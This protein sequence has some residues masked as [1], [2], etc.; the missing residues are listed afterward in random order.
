MLIHEAKMGI[1]LKMENFSVRLK[2]LNFN[3]IKNSD[4]SPHGRRH[5]FIIKKLSLSLYIFSGPLAYNYK[6]L[7]ELILS[8]RTVQRIMHKD[9]RHIAEGEFRFDMLVKH[10]EFYKGIKVKSG[11]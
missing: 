5:N 10:I 2:R 4:K 3:S 6:N 8:L 9:Y 1:Q 11:I 7:P